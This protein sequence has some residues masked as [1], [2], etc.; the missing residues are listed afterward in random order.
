LRANGGQ[1]N[2]TFLD[3]FAFVVSE[4]GKYKLDDPQYPF[5]LVLTPQGGEDVKVKMQFPIVN[6]ERQI[7]LTLIPGCTGN[8][9]QYDLAKEK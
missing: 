9:Y 2:Y 6:G 1:G 5:N 7:S 4:P 3:N 8:T